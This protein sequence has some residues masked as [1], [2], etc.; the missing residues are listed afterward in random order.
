MQFSSLRIWW[1]FARYLTWR[2]FSSFAILNIV[3][4]MTYGISFS[5]SFFQ[6]R[7]H[8][9]KIFQNWSFLAELSLCCEH[10][11][12]GYILKIAGRRPLKNGHF[13]PLYTSKT[14][15]C[16]KTSQKRLTFWQVLSKKD[17]R[18]LKNHIGKSSMVIMKKGVFFCVLGVF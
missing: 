12:M 14:Q 8:S 1:R 17:N 7:F 11:R 9:Y 10:W 2:I 4:Y 16:E 13:A 18:S 15:S 3:T 5:D 6:P